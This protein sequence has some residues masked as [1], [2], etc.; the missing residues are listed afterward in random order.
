MSSNPLPKWRLR[1]LPF[2][3][4]LV[5]AVFLCSV[6]IGYLSALFQVHVQDASA[7]QALPDA[8]TMEDKFHGRDGI[9]VIERLVTADESLPFTASGTMKP[10]FTTKSAGWDQAAEELARATAK[11]DKVDFDALEDADQAKRIEAAKPELHK[12]RDGESLALARW[13]HDPDKKAYDDDRYSLPD[14]MQ[15]LVITEKFVDRDSA[16]KVSVKIKTLIDKRCSRCHNESNRTASG[17]APLT[18]FWRM[19]AFAGDKQ[20]RVGAISVHKLAQSTHVHLLGFSMLFFLTGFLFAMTNWPAIVRFIIAPTALVAQMVDISFW[21]LARV[22]DP[23]GSWFAQGVVITG[24][25]VGVCVCLQ[26]VLTLFSLF[27]RVG[28]GVLFVLIVLAGLGVWQ[29]EPWV[30]GYLA[31]E[32]K[33][34]KTN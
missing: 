13:L 28:K 21:W 16:G 14:D 2:V 33:A 6:G 17:D 32:V 20:S 30:K 27:G 12:Q 18:D 11:K 22:D 4:R 7:G 23:W 19:K 34:V 29:A 26:I 10:A 5:I 25:I 3:A 8:K 9:S 24:G 1:D 15:G 31:N